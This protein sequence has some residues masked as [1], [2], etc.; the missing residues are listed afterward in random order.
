LAAVKANRIKNLELISASTLIVG[1]DGHAKSNI[2]AFRL[3]S[4]QEPAG[5]M[6]FSNDRHGFERL[7]VKVKAVMGARKLTGAVFVLEPNGPYWLLLARYLSERNH[8]VRV[9]SPLQVKR[10]RQT[11]DPSPDKNDYKDARSVA[12]LGAQGK[13]NQ[14]SLAEPVYEELR[15][16]SNLRERLMVDRSS[17][18]HVLRSLVARS[19]PELCGC[20]RD[21]F[22]KSVLAL[23]RAAPTAG[24]VSELGVETVTEVIKS[25]SKG[26]FGIKKAREIVRA[27][28]ESVGY[29]EASGAIRTEMDVL[30]SMLEDIQEKIGRLEYEMSRLLL[31]TAEGVLVL[32]V[33]GIGWVT[34]AMFLGE[35]G[36]LRQYSSASQIGKLAGLDLVMEQSADY[37]SAS[38]IS[39]R[40]RKL[41]RKTLYQ[42]ALASL[43]CNDRV[44]GFYQSLISPKRARTLKKKQAIVAVMGKLVRIIFS[45]VRSGRPYEREHVWVTPGQEAVSLMEAA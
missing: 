23:L 25:F 43:M 36:S 32:S 3:S 40:G 11:E 26:R 10:N 42:M 7:L 37:C 29:L 45:V 19:F 8:V 22:C 9:V 4:Y 27:A 38:R 12:D 13:F 1:V 5:P 30:V 34:A 6:R 31:E 41:L 33:P 14:T 20:V 2:A 35:T 15:L 24:A 28:S 39:K 16:L 18:K 21:M 17:Y 44:V